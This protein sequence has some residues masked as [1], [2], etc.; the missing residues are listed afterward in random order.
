[1]L[2][3]P[4][5]QQLL[6]WI[7]QLG[8]LGIEPGIGRWRRAFSAADTRAVE[9]ITGWMRAAGLTVRRDAAGNLYGRRA[10]KLTGARVVATGSHIDSVK[11]GGKFDGVLGALTGLAAVSHLLETHGDPVMPLEVVAICGEEGSRFPGGFLGSFGMVGRLDDAELGKRDLQ[12]I[13]MAEAMCAAG[14]DPGALPGAVRTDL[15]AFVELHIEQG[16]VL[17]RKGIPIGVVTGIVGLKFVRARVTGR[18]DHAGTTPMDLRSD[19]LRGAMEIYL[20]ATRFVE[21]A[22]G[23]SVITCGNIAVSPGATNIV[24]GLVE[25][26]IDLRDADAGHLQ[27]LYDEVYAIARRITASRGLGLDWDVFNDVPPVPCAPHLSEAIR[28]ACGALEIPFL[29]MPSGA[30]HDAQVLA[31][32][33]PVAMLFVPSVDGRSHCPDEHTRPDDIHRGASVLAETLYRLAYS[34]SEVTV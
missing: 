8:E 23:A 11:N 30:G 9:L 16:G 32:L 25:F 3:E 27:W 15:G 19:A 12:G 4:R 20:E 28:A 7:D 22:G 13:T 6:S 21:R 31:Q 26:T 17:D 5:L 10:G 33:C 29:D 2:P 24:P 18:P 34:P 1:M 14:L